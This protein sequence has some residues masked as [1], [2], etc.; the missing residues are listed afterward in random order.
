MI[1]KALIT[2]ATSGIG[3]ALAKLLAAKKITLILTGRNQNKLEALATVLS[4]ETKVDI[5]T[6]DLGNPLER[7][8]VLLAIQQHIPDL[9][10]N[11][12]GF[13]IYGDVLSTGT[14]EQMNVLEVNGAALLE[15][16]LEGA[17]A[18][19]RAGKKG[20]ILNMSSVAGLM[21]M[22]GMAVYGAAKAFVTS[23][24]EAVDTELQ[25]QGIRVLVFSPGQVATGFANRAAKRK[26]EKREG[27]L[28]TVEETARR[29]VKQ[30]EKCEGSVIFD[31]RYRL[32]I[33]LAKAFLPTILY[34]KIIWNNIRKR[35]YDLS[36]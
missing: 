30:I 4:Q 10:I 11:N 36:L 31:W 33:W 8:K 28:L 15:C 23:F 12:A 7:K 16:T 5:V 29:I 25:D 20:V 19:K 13:G 18:L 1:E 32:L 22:P 17:H 27:P 9:V 35:L 24:S 14:S 34:K 26:V 2:G 6:A 3:E 21:P